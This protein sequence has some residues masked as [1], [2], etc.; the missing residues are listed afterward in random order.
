MNINLDSPLSLAGPVFG[1]IGFIGYALFIIA[2]LIVHIFFAIAVL[3][4]SY[5]L[6]HRQGRGTILVGGGMWA[7]A[8]LLGGV[9]VA[10]IYWIIHYSTLRPSP[11]QQPS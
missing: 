4:D 11:P 2:I 1:T 6:I 7:L 5:H 3:K 10:A 8:T 9:F